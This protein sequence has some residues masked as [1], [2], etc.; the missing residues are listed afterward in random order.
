MILLKVHT[1]QGIENH[2]V[3][4]FPC[5]V[6]RA[7][8]NEIVI[9]DAS[10]SAHHAVID[11]SADGY[12][13]EDHDSTNGLRVKNILQKRIAIK[14][15]IEIL[16]G[17][18]TIELRSSKEV[19]S[20]TVNLNLR[21]I[22]NDRFAGAPAYVKAILLGAALVL[23]SFLIQRFLQAGFSGSEFAKG[24]LSALVLLLVTG[25]GFALWSKVQTKYY[26]YFDFVTVLIA[27][28]LWTLLYIAFADFI[29]FNVNS[30]WFSTALDILAISGIVFVLGFSAS[31]LLFP[32]STARARGRF[33]V[34]L[35]FGLFLLTYGFRH[36]RDERFETAQL[37][38]SIGYPLR[39]FSESEN[40]IDKFENKMSELNLELE[41]Q[42]L[43]LA[44][45]NA[46]I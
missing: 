38:S 13:I 8:D 6:G 34:S 28:S 40:G 32:Y 35:I 4:D 9:N 37:N 2:R 25:A 3:E 27:T 24:Q 30:D 21:D 41:K 39:N 14:K 12:Y 7:L 15:P 11:I 17:D 18:V 33:V 31:G 44:K 1:V 10:V 20:Q 29:K 43:E 46:E 42:R 5:R 26:R 22:K 19:S 36:F 45:K 23:C 16:L